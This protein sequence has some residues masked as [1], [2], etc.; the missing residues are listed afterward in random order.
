MT[1]IEPLEVGGVAVPGQVLTADSGEDTGEAPAIDEVIGKMREGQGRP[2]FTRRIL[3]LRRG[4][5][6]AYFAP[7]YQQL[8]L[9]ARLQAR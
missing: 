2:D 5:T 9:K 6:E 4:E 8:Q 1:I 3:F 7:G